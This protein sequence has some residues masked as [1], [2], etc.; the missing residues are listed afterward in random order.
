MGLIYVTLQD[1]EDMSENG[2]VNGDFDKSKNS[3]FYV[4]HHSTILVRNL[5]YGVNQVHTFLTAYQSLLG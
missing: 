3:Q 4:D 5:A 2:L 1:I